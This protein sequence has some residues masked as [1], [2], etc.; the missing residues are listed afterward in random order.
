M[1]RQ[2]G[3][4]MIANTNDMFSLSRD[5]IHIQGG[6]KCPEH[7]LQIMSLLLLRELAAMLIRLIEILLHQRAQLALKVDI[8]AI[9]L[10]EYLLILHDVHHKV[11]SKADID[12]LR[13]Q[14]M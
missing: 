11:L 14:K 8:M 10:F 3:R 6:S 1:M 9:A 7:G 13:H 12:I 2:V 4:H 5:I